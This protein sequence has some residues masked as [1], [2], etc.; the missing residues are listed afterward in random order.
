MILRVFTFVICFDVTWHLG[1]FGKSKKWIRGV[2]G[3]VSSHTHGW[4]R[5]SSSMP[6][7]FF[8]I[9]T[10]SVLLRYLYFS[11]TLLFS[12]KTFLRGN[13]FWEWVSSFLNGNSGNGSPLP[14]GR[15]GVV[16]VW[17][18]SSDSD[19]SR[20]ILEKTMRVGSGLLDMLR[21]HLDL[22]LL[23]VPL[24]SLVFLIQSIG[25]CSSLD[26]RPIRGKNV[27]TLINSEAFKT[28]DDNDA[29]SLCCVG[30]LQL[31]LLGL[32][33]RRLVSNWILR[34]WPALYATQP[35]DEV[36]KK[37]Y[38]ITGFAWAFKTWILESFR[39]ATNDYYTRHRRLPRI[40]AW[41]SKNKFYQK[42]LNPFLHRLV[43]DEIEARSRWW[44]SSRAYF[45]GRNIEEE[46][47]PRHLNRNNYFKVPSEMYREFEEQI[48]GYKQM[49]E[50]RDDMYEKMS[51]FMEDVSAGPVPLAKEP[52]IADQHYG[53]SDL[54]G[55]R[56]ISSFFNM[57][58]PSNWQTPIPSYFGTPNSQPPIP[59]HPDTRNWQNPMTSYSPNLPHPMPSHSHDAGLLNT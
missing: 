26:D 1:H 56:A 10:F 34:R 4:D 37:S 43:P 45:D 57:A 13:A 54:S 3:F 16:G 51:R 14:F 44:V 52:I 9:L 49:M 27:E 23:S 53:I 47:I 35:K 59:S 17:S 21:E 39:A 41:S 55:F 46:R 11:R 30:I 15:S 18:H 6:D 24:L 8:S 28:L 5:S 2:K 20:L 58:T 7:L 22:R 19:L 25:V 12:V 40:V 42:M 38:S 31:V 50:K 32:E 48:G 29:V 33:Y 36:D